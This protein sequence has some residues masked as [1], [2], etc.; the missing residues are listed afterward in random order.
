MQTAETVL[1]VLGERGRRG[2][3][4]E[5]LYRQ[6]YNRQLYLV[7]Y[8]NIYSNSGAMTPGVDGETA[9]GMS[10][11]RI[12]E[13]IEAIRFERYRFAPARRVYI[14]KKDGRLR[15]LGMP[16]WKDKLVAEVV[17]LL[18]QAYYEPRFSDHSHGF[19][20]KRG[21]HT[22][23]REI[24]NTWTG[25][26]WF[27]ELD[28]TDCFGSLDHQV[29]LRTLGE[30]IVDNRFLALVRNMLQAGYLEDWIY[31]ATYSGAPQGGVASPILSN[32]YLDKMDEYVETVLMPQYTRGAARTNNRTYSRLKE[33]LRRA[34][35]VGDPDQIRQLTAELRRLPSRDTNDPGYRRLRYIRYADDA[36]LGFAGP[37][38]E[39]LQIK[40]QLID[41][42]R[43][44]LALEANPA[45]TLLT[46]GRTDS[47]RFLNYHIGTRHADHYVVNGQRRGNGPIMLGVPPD[48]IRAQCARYLHR[49]KPA[50]RREL[51][52]HD[53]YHIVDRIAAEYR[54]VVQ[55]WQL[56]HNIARMGKLSWVATT[57]L[58]KTL[59]HKH[60]STVTKIANKHKATTGT[61]DGPRRCFE[62]LRWRGNGKPPLV[63]RFGGIPLKRQ[64]Q[65]E[66]TDPR[67]APTCPPVKEVVKR[68]RN[69]RC[70][71]CRSSRHISVHAVR[72]LAD[73]EQTGTPQPPWASLMTRRRRKTLI[74]CHACHDAIHQ[75]KPVTSTN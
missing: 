7:A 66:I 13:I 14:P 28:I 53:D 74:V 65:A 22:A 73:L 29:M 39:A 41:F 25:T 57:S 27:I 49:G 8:G 12:D 67:P 45:K 69:G 10:L 2:L 42:L 58:L 1:S 4:C 20:P 52:N 55:Y 23:L 26:T 60:Q 15:P 6:L 56:A 19:R 37:K 47:A 24:E 54:G 17:R 43:H 40:D 34:R 18:L 46:H 63:A 68:L 35:R 9:D 70:E 44:H 32:I 5:E 16:T 64:K 21:C 33:Q 75:R 38:A 71:L 11:D 36:L 31:N 30:N 61:P 62:A 51:V 3:P 48:V 59:A 72:R 50:S